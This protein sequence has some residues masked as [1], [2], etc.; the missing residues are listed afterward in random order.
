M[1]KLYH[2]FHTYGTFIKVSVDDYWAV[3]SNRPH[4]AYRPLSGV[5][6]PQDADV[7]WRFN[8]SP[9]PGCRVGLHSNTHSILVKDPPP[10]TQ[11]INEAKNSLKEESSAPPE[12]YPNMRPSS[13]FSTNTHHCLCHSMRIP[14]ETQKKIMLAFQSTIS[15]RLLPSSG[16]FPS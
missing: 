1:P 3:L 16:A 2:S 5:W 7:I 6:C 8:H 12:C 15:Y 14:N 4:T 10:K 13:C 11:R 9:S